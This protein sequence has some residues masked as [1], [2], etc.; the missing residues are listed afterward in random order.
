MEDLVYMLFVEPNNKQVNLNAD[1]DKCFTEEKW[2]LKSSL[3]KD[4]SCLKKQSENEKIKWI[5][6]K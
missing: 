2:R 5:Y 3:S 6:L 4:N 1:R